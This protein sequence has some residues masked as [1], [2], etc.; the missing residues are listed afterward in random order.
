[1][2]LFS[3]SSQ[4]L[5]AL[6]L[7]DSSEF[8]II[9]VGKDKYKIHRPIAIFISPIIT[10]LLQDDPD[11]EKFE[12]QY[13]DV[14][15][16]F[17]TIVQLA[18][19]NSVKIDQSNRNGIEYLAKALGNEEILDV[20]KK[21]D[22]TDVSKQK[23]T[24][25]SVCNLIKSRN[26]LQMPKDDC[27]LFAARHF[28]AIKESDL[29]SLDYEDLSSILSSKDLIVDTETQLFNFILSLVK[30]HG[31]RYSP[32]FGNVLFEYIG[33]EEMADFVTL[34][35]GND[36]NETV[37]N[38]VS[39]RLVLPLRPVSEMKERHRTVDPKA[40]AEAPS[41]PNSRRPSPG[42]ESKGSQ[43]LIR[44]ISFNGTDYFHGVFNRLRSKRNHISMS[45]SSTNTGVL[46]SLINP[47]STTNFWTQNQQDSWIRVD[48]KK[49]RL[50]PTSYSLR[51]RFDHDFNQCQ[52]WN[53]EG[54]R[55]G[56]WHVLDS[57]VNEPLKVK[58]PKNFK[59]T[60]EST[61][62]SFRIKQT[63]LNT[64]GDN[65]LVLSGFEVFGDLYPN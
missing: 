9:C 57:H 55:G 24:I 63:G 31:N 37:W 12:I 54:L 19:G 5:G 11:I 10:E 27:I 42:D 3:L 23:I 8:F 53:F 21:L 40:P 36:L 48:L 20:V 51:G 30:K 47:S 41:I 61:F 59:V 14:N 64:Y 22:E 62:N 35:N 17:R 7:V 44:E 15:R 39:R 46:S 58:A 1:M 29:E 65:D 38:A 32:L 34:F 28:Y 43:N 45:S 49:N 25:T 4:G 50:H 26:K 6:K 13:N 33:D 2:T 16:D 18:Y 56:K 52:S 60:T